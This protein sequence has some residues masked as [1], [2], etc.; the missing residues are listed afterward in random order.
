VILSASGL[1]IDYG[2]GREMRFPIA[3]VDFQLRYHTIRLIVG[4]K[5]LIAE[6][7]LNRAIFMF[8]IHVRC[9]M[10][11]RAN[12]CRYKFSP[13]Q[14]VRSSHQ[15]IESGISRECLESSH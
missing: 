15:V 12:A 13:N 10:C 11:D 3:I 6:L 5:I 1:E 14:S 8:A 2:I 4:K 9:A 7:L